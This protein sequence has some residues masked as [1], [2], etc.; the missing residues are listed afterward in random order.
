MSNIDG[1]EFFNP[2]DTIK[3]KD[4]KGNFFFLSFF[5]IDI[6]IYIINDFL[7]LSDFR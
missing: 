2:S 6:S 4:I 1:I 7:I 5:L 3:D